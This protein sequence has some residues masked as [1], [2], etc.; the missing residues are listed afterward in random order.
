MGA[1]MR[2]ILASLVLAG[3]ALSGPV[4]FHGSATFLGEQAWI[5]TDSGTQ[6][7]SDLRFNLNIL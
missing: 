1:P 6:S 7:L 4:Q 3:I 2:V 5:E